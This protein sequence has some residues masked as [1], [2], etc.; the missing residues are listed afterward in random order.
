MHVAVDEAWQE[1]V[2][3]EPDDARVGGDAELSLPADCR[4]A[5]PI[6]EYDRGVDR[7]RSTTVEQ[8]G[9]DE[10]K[11]GGKILRGGRSG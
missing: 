5:L 8:R 11:H 7:S 6:D 3:V 9:A 10:G 1:R 4:D 2:A